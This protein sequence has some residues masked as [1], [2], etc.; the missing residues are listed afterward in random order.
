[1]IGSSRQKVDSSRTEYSKAL[2]GY[3]IQSLGPEG[4][5]ELSQKSGLF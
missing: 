5:S 1:V 4:V 2:H 3:E